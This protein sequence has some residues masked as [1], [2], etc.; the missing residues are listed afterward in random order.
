MIK[1]RQQ[2]NRAWA[3]LGLVILAFVGL[4]CRLTDLQVWRHDELAK[5]AEVKSVQTT[6]HPARR[7]DILDANGNQ[8]ATSV[9]V[10]TICADPSLIGGQQHIVARALAPLLGMPEADLYQRL[11][12]R[13]VKNVRGETFTNGLHYVRLQKNVTD[14][15]WQ[16]I[17]TTMNRLNFG[18]DE[19]KLSKAGR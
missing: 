12:P 15:T 13:V 18:V 14:D 3:L 17:Q 6:W 19:T 10:K 8:L 5:M 11:I 7:G 1:Q 4:A 2:F 16:K 9:F